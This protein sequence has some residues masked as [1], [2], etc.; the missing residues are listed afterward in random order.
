MLK[1]VR[2]VPRVVQQVVLRLLCAASPLER[3]RRSD[4]FAGFY[5]GGRLY[6]MNLSTVL[7][8]LPASGVI[9]L[10]CHPGSEE[11]KGGRDWGYAWAAERDALTSPGV[12]ALVLA[13]GMQLI[14]GRSSR[15]DQ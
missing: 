4:D 7:A 11:M 12:R 1:S 5:F 2:H 6:E 9:E 14:S 13:R 15:A 3:L 8:G 10:M